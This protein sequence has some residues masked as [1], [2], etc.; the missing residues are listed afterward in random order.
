MSEPSPTIK[1]FLQ[2]AEDG[3][4]LLRS[5]ATPRKKLEKQ[6]EAKEAKSSSSPGLQSPE[7]EAKE[8]ME[9]QAR[10]MLG[11]D[12][13]LRGFDL[14]FKSLEKAIASAAELAAASSKCG[15]D[16]IEAATAAAAAVRVEGEARC[17]D[18]SKRIDALSKPLPEDA[19]RV[20][21]WLGK[22]LQ[23]IEKRLQNQ[24]EQKTEELFEAAESMVATLKAEVHMEIV[25]LREEVLQGKGIVKPQGKAEEALEQRLK[26]AEA[27]LRRAV[28]G[29]AELETRVQGEERVYWT[30]VQSLEQRVGSL[31][32]RD[33][34][35]VEGRMGKLETEIAKLLQ[36]LPEAQPERAT[37]DGPVRRPRGRLRSE[38]VELTETDQ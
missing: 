19:E 33:G 16:G 22:D 27:D 26:T 30:V 37:Q 15:R 25:A 17:R 28:H 12:R 11:L 18:L 34:T 10:T 32:A 35:S 36:K 21:A 20:Q 6:Q 31:E 7:K 3:L 14:R 1:G 2:Q 4:A 23:C 5:K 29:V 13:R 38:K 8:Q 9:V 24:L